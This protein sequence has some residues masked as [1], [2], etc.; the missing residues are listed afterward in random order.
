MKKCLFLLVLT[1]IGPTQHLACYTIHLMSDTDATQFGEMEVQTNTTLAQIRLEIAATFGLPNQ[2]LVLMN[3]NS[4]IV[5]GTTI[6]DAGLAQGDTI[7]FTLDTEQSHDIKQEKEE[8]KSREEATLPLEIVQAIEKNDLT[9]VKNYFKTYSL[10]QKEEDLRATPLLIAAAYSLAIFDYLL[11]K[12]ANIKATD[13]IGQTALHYAATNKNPKEFE[14]IATTILKS[15]IAIDTYD[16]KG[17]TPLFIAAHNLNAYAAEFFIH[18]GAK[19]IVSIFEPLAHD[20]TNTKEQ[21]MQIKMIEILLR[22]GSPVDAIDSEGYS[23]VHRAVIENKLYLVPILVKHKANLTVSDKIHNRT[24]QETAKKIGKE[25]EF[26]AAVNR[27]L[28]EAEHEKE[29]GRRKEQNTK[30]C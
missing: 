15:G 1:L 14:A 22:H 19:E 7:L 18:N 13:D 3:A 5:S 10:E 30:P 24:A 25:K 11:S 16:E 27:G 29:K 6:G 20:S 26:L 12:G 23:I 2:S 8:K 21:D 4:E 9:R 28:K 17:D